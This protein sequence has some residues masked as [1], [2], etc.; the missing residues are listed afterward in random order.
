VVFFFLQP[1]A[2]EVPEITPRPTPSTFNLLLVIRLSMLFWTYVECL[3]FL[4]RC[5]AQ[6]NDHSVIH[7]YLKTSVYFVL[8]QL[9]LF[10]FTIHALSH[11]FISDVTLPHYNVFATPYVSKQ[12]LALSRL[13]HS[14][15]CSSTVFSHKALERRPAQETLIC[16]VRLRDTKK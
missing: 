14:K 1:N 7:Y 2:G 15:H 3:P 5:T 9:Y 4:L 6:Q 16:C 13:M 8:P 12:Q 11:T 10:P